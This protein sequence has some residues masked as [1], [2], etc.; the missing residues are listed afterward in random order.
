MVLVLLTVLLTALSVSG[1]LLLRDVESNVLK[2]TE[3]RGLET[4]EHLSRSL[5]FSMVGYDYHTIQLLLEQAVQ[6]GAVV[7]AR[8][9]SD[10]GNVMA[11]AEHASRND[12][13][14]MNFER[15]V[16]LDGRPL[17]QLE[18]ELSIEP[19]ARQLAAQKQSLIKRELLVIVL[20]ALGEFLIL[21]WII[22]RPLTRVS[23]ALESNVDD[24]GVILRDIP[25][26]S[27]DEI[28]ELARQ[29]NRMRT[30]LNTANQKLQGRIEAADRELR[31]AYQKLLEQSDALRQSNAELERL[32]LT[33]PLTGLGNRRLFEKCIETDMALFRRHGDL[34]SLLVLD[35]DRFK[36]VN[37]TYGHDVGDTILC[38]FAD[39]LRQH[40]RETDAVCRLGGEEFAVFLRRTD[41]PTAMEIAEKLRRR[42]EAMVVDSPAGARVSVTASIGAAILSRP[43]NLTSAEALYKAADEAMYASKQR[44]RNRSTH[45]ESLSGG[46]NSPADTLT[47]EP[48][49]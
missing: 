19:I 21:S 31:D 47:G 33:D 6:A 44:G 42:L 15:T 38:R 26:D 40:M 24:N 27:P 34:S 22:I 11:E 35:L 37:D 45:I 39:L 20:I 18:L 32:S 23:R 7:H 13:R 14:R 29:F 41:A 46:A 5:A 12:V 30:Q 3:R 2:E 36:V 25:V 48:H 1:W 49:R 28:G 16:T 4:A 8:V 10:R 17:G 9:L 43:L